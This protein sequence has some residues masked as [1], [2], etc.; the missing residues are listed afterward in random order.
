MKKTFY[1]K[2][3]LVLIAFSNFNCLISQEEV[4][5]RK[6]SAEPFDLP[7]AIIYGD[8]QVSVSSGVKQFP[9]KTR[10]LNLRELDSINSLEKQQ[11]NNLNPEQLKTDVQ[12]REYSN[13]YLT[14]EFGRFTNPKLDIGYKFAMGNYKLYANGGFDY[15]GGHLP[16]ADYTKGNVLLVS[17]YIAPEKFWLFGG[18]KTRTTLMFNNNTYNT[19]ADS[20]PKARSTNNMKFNLDVDGNY[21]GFKFYT[22]AGFKYFALSADNNTSENGF[23]AFL[24]VINPLTD[25]N[26]GADFSFDMNTLRGK[27]TK[28]IN[29]AG[30]A[31]LTNGNIKYYSE[32]G[33]QLSSNSNEVNYFN[34]LI[35]AGFDYKFNREVTFKGDL[36]SGRNWNEFGNL[37]ISNPYLN[38]NALLDYEYNLVKIKAIAQ[39]HPIDNF[40]ISGGLSFSLIKNITTFVDSSLSTFGLGYFDGNKINIFTDVSY[41]INSNSKLSGFFSINFANISDSSKNVPYLPI[42]NTKIVYKYNVNENFYT[43]LFLNYVG[44]KFADIENKVEIPAYINLG[45]DVNYK[46]DEKMNLFI[47]FDNILNQEIY[48]WN[49]YKERG[50]FVSLGITWQF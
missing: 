5:E 1:I 13:G 16:M 44:S 28:L 26:V 18:S 15:F 22:G 3:I 50:I 29:I 21:N 4:K 35:K 25:M 30:L 49:K 27:G 9:L 14:G 32:L 7:N 12:M 43:N 8:A 45:L 38:S 39:Y 37:M 46:Y 11:T 31:D 10:P 42:L 19:Y 40:N 24:K 2:L 41:K 36:Q 47:K 6:K 20:T 23:S 48:I 34:P 33:I 17:D